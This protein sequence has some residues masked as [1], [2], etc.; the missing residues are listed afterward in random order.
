MPVADAPSRTERFGRLPDLLRVHT[1]ILNRNERLGISGVYEC[2]FT[3]TPARN[4]STNSKLWSMARKRPNARSAPAINWPRSSPY[5]RFQHRGL[6][7]RRLGPPE[8]AAPAATPAVRAP[9]R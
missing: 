9:A 5:S 7:P 6:R 8:A 4:A 1:L 3:N 2:R